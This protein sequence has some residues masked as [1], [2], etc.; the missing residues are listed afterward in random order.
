MNEVGVIGGMAIVTVLIRYPALALS[1]R[2]KLSPQFLRA[3]NYVPPVVLTAIVVP[4]VLMP[5]GNSLDL[6]HSNA[7]LIGAIVAVLV[8][9]WRQNLLWTI[10]M[11][12][13][14]FFGWQGVLKLL[15]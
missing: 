8:G 11:G 6:S 2:L 13:L 9:V 14:A 4:A 12:M 3:L 15:S 5:T 1:G 10:G 7:R